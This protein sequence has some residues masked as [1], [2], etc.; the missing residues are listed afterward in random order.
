MVEYAPINLPERM[1]PG[2]FLEQSFRMSIKTSNIK[3]G[4]K[5]FYTVQSPRLTIVDRVSGNQV[6]Y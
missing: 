3:R 4:S 1:S 6:R 2:E 5:R